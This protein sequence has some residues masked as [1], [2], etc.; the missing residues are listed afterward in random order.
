MV[1]ASKSVPSTATFVGAG[2]LFG[3]L[4]LGLGRL[5]TR[6]LYILFEPHLL[7]VFPPYEL[8]PSRPLRSLESLEINCI[9]LLVSFFLEFLN[10]RH[11]ELTHTDALD[12][13][14]E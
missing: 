6:P 3:D 2:G 10:L 4:S 9:N 1:G 12:P 14:R 7:Y 13:V 8:L 11:G 5:S